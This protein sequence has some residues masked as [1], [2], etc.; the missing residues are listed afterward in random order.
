M[1][2]INLANFEDRKNN[3]QK[4]KFLNVPLH[5]QFK[6]PHMK[7]HKIKNNILFVLSTLIAYVGVSLL[8]VVKNFVI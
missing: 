6:K 1:T 5:G 8:A 3:D 4:L 2:I 7:R